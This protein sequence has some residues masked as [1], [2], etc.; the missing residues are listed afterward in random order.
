[1]RAARAL[2]LCTIALLFV[3]LMRQGAEE[4]TFAE[5][6]SRPIS[7]EQ[8]SY[9]G[10]VAR[11][12]TATSSGNL[13]ILVIVTPTSR[14][15]HLS[16]AI[17]HVLPLRKCF[18]VRWI[19]VHTMEDESVAR[20]SFYREVFPWIKEIRTFNPSA[21]VEG[22]HERN[23]AMQYILH[24]VKGNNGFVYFLDDDNTLPD[25]CELMAGEG[26]KTNTM[27]F[28]DQTH[29]GAM[30]RNTDSIDV[31][32]NLESQFCRLDAGNF[33]FPLQVIRETSLTHRWSISRRDVNPLCT[34]DAYASSLAGYW[35]AKGSR[36]V[37]RLTSAFHVKHLSETDGCI[38]FPFTEA[39]LH[40]SLS[41]YQS[42]LRKMEAVHD[43][44][45]AKDRQSQQHISFHTYV[46]ILGAIRRSLPADRQARYLEIGVWKGGTSLLMSRHEF[47][48]SVIGVDV[49]AYRNQRSEAETM[50]EALKG[51]GPITW[52]NSSS[53]NRY[54]VPRVK[55]ELAGALLDMLFID[56]N[57]STKGALADFTNFA[58][59]VAP[60][61][62][63]IFD[64]YMDTVSS[65]GVREAVW[66]LVRDG[67]IN[68]NDYDIIGTVGNVAG[69]GHWFRKGYFYDW[70]VTTSNEYVLRKKQR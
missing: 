54:I 13:P 17:F 66:L 30:V 47:P 65:D 67:V 60:G 39:L 19:V 41:E 16:R 35:I 37:Q 45:P 64:D 57:H 6:H 10:G 62:F 59:L 46:H 5:P 38:P 44:I 15:Y 43:K 7:I 51:S 14:P 20:A 32:S 24:H 3:L 29:C 1:M 12:D 4:I 69:A 8:F 23:V 34:V 48:T 58:P 68:T 63:I 22:S 56:G 11:D 70:Q 25:L 21:T 18:D 26:L 53:T 49:F 50:Q 42:L 27:Y 9:F 52:L 28:A 61:G 55:R 36:S 31:Q 40:E 2:I 33:L